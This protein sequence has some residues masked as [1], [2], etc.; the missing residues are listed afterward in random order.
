M[1][2][3]L[4]QGSLVPGSWQS[5]CFAQHHAGGG[6]E[7]RESQSPLLCVSDGAFTGNGLLSIFPNTWLAVN[8]PTQ[9]HVLEKI[10]LK[11][12]G[13]DHIQSQQEHPHS[14]AGRNL[15]TGFPNPQPCFGQP[16]EPRNPTTHGQKRSSTRETR[17]LCW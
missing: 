10:C 17:A 13:W 2:P 5:S 16:C 15:C 6:C 1:L 4:Q 9:I 12:P 11:P 8:K 3:I 7:F 14:R